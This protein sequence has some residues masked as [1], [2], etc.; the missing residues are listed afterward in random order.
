MRKFPKTLV[1]AVVLV[2]SAFAALAVRAAAPAGRYVVAADTVLDTKTGL[3]WQR[4]VP[5]ANHSWAEAGT[6]CQT[7]DLAGFATG[8]RLPTK[9]ELES[10]VDLRTSLP[11][12][13]TAAFPNTSGY[14]YF[15]TSTVSGQDPSRVYMVFFYDG[16]TITTFKASQNNFLTRCVR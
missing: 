14:S 4:A 9:K 1:V 6:Y 10:L 16:N 12:I 8:W 7:L 13:D 5:K 15:W 2:A 3:T 11:C